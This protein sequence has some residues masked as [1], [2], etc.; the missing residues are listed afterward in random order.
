MELLSGIYETFLG[1]AQREMGAF[2]TPRHLASLAVDEAF[3]GIDKPWEEVVLDGACL[4]KRC[5]YWMTT[6]CSP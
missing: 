1:G 3:R 4:R 2:Y 5:R 6:G